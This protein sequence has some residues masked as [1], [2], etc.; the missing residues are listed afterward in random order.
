MFESTKIPDDW[1]DYLRAADE[2]WVP[3]KWNQQV[4]D[5]SGIKTKVVPLGYDEEAYTFV[6][7][8]PAKKK[9]RDFVFLH[10]NAFNIRKGFTE[11]WK[12]FTKEFEKT[13]PVKLILKTD[14]NSSPLPITKSEYPNIE[15]IYGK[16]T[17]AE[18]MDIM[19]RSDCFVFPSR[20]EGFGM[21]PLECMATGMP[22]I[23]PNAHG[24]TEYF[25]A[26]YM[27]EVKVKE[28]CPA[29]YAR[30]KDIDVGKM[31]VSDVDDLRAKM[32]WCVNHQEDVI[33]MGKKASEYV[34]QWTY[35]NSFAHAIE[36]VK[37]IMQMEIK[38]SKL[39]NV[40]T[41]ERVR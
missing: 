10:Y 13:E 12:A 27:Y 32:R 21:N 22:A 20:G 19:R 33:T 34:K 2:V 35:T 15:I 38:P 7:R 8:T 3:S 31:Y 36:R 6:E 26:D 24:L 25:N 39:Q 40:L 14:G 30:Y 41:L 9:R 23:L 18:M 28:E 29:L 16:I 1:L 4:F 37:E 17:E 5:R 11:V